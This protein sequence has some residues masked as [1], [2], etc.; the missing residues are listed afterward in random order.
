MSD[1]VLFGTSGCH[2]CEQ[3]EQLLLQSGITTLTIQDII[4]DQQW[5]SAYG[6]IIPVLLHP[7]SGRQLNWPFDSDRLQTFL[8]STA[9]PCN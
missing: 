8:V 6:L 1:Y 2:L 7:T 9:T 5:L 3:A 4:D